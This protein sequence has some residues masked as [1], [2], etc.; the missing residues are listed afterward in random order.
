MDIESIE[1]AVFL[2]NCQIAEIRTR[3]P[4][5]ARGTF[6]SVIVLSA[7]LKGTFWNVSTV[8]IAIANVAASVSIVRASA[9]IATID[10]KIMVDDWTMMMAATAMRK[11]GVR[12]SLGTKVN[13]L[14]D[15]R[16]FTFVMETF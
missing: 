8:L 11:D 9:K 14:T 12:H 13:I 15:D 10:G 3:L 6:T 4:E 7:L 16:K 1:I 5:T 2:C